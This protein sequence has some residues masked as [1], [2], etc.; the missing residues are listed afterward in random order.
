MKIFISQIQQNGS[1]YD[2]TIADDWVEEIF[3]QLKSTVNYDPQSVRG[4]VHL[5]KQDHSNIVLTGHFQFDVNALCARCGT[6]LKVPHYVDLGHLFAETPKGQKRA[7][8]KEPKEELDETDDLGI[9]FF[10]TD[11]IDISLPIND[12]IVLDIPLN[13]Y[14]PTN[15]QKE[16]EERTQ[17][18]LTKFKEKHSPAIDPRW[19]KLKNFKTNKQ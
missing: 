19:E 7:K 1:D 14:C 17:Q 18:L 13:D 2:F 16:C 9:T 6:E 12:Q 15:R 10:D 4:H 5:N 8:E 11:V 3:S